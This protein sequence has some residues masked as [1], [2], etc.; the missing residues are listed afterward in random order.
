MSTTIYGP[1]TPSKDDI[2]L[3]E[4]SSRTLARHIKNNLTVQIK[5]SGEIV[6]L[7]VTAV[8]LLVDLLSAMAAGNAVTLVPIHAELTTQQA[9][10]LLNI[11][12]PWL[13]KL[14]EQGK[15]KYHKIGTHRRILFKDLMEYQRKNTEER[16]KALDE[17][18]AQAQEL[19]LGY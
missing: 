4:T 17:L 9:A 19:G 5:E 12:R 10:E 16:E 3:A 11:S 7:P 8:R 2:H 15:L 6:Q 13:I 18:A 1:V 14:L